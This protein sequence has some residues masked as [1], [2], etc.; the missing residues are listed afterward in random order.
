MRTLF[1][2]LPL[3]FSL[4]LFSQDNTPH[5]KGLT[6]KIGPRYLGWTDVSIPNPEEYG[7]EITFSEDGQY[8]KSLRLYAGYFLSP[9][10]S[11]NLGFGLDRYEGY[12]AN[13]APLVVQG[14][15]YLSPGKNSFF[16]S[17]EV[18]TQIAFSE[19]LDKGYGFALSLGRE[20][21]FSDKTGLNVYLG[22]NFQQSRYEHE[23][24]HPDVIYLDKLNRKSF[25]IGV[26]FVVF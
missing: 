4:N 2:I 20:I 24:K 15:Y 19:N 13:T 11:L 12:S 26:D 21:A 16:A 3:L 25:I 7:E 14:N 9:Q 18:G 10:L 22:Y 8:G 6:F 23:N 17:A 5:R 1:F